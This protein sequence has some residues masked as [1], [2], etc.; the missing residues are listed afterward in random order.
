MNFFGIWICLVTLFVIGMGFV[1]V[2]RGERYFGYLWW[3]YIMG[4]GALCIFSSLFIANDWA[5]ALCGAAGASLIWGSTELKEQAVRG[6]LGWY[7]FNGKKIDPPF[8]EKIKKWKAPS[9]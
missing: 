9:L 4:F 7:P 1:W 5:S 6:E 2:I 8:V 3:P